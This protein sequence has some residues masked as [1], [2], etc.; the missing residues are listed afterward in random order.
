MPP[1]G[2]SRSIKLK[3]RAHIPCTVVPDALYFHGLSAD[4]P[5]AG[6]TVSVT[7]DAHEKI[8]VKPLNVDQVPPSLAARPELQTLYHEAVKMA[9]TGVPLVHLLKNKGDAYQTLY[10][11]PVTLN[12]RTLAGVL[13]GLSCDV[14][15]PAP[16]ASQRELIANLLACD[17]TP[18][19]S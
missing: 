12:G 18:V 13:V 3:Y 7:T 14:M 15:S 19:H 4:K 8:K 16:Q 9:S 6:V 5:A 11:C 10:A 1:F 2:K 17:Q